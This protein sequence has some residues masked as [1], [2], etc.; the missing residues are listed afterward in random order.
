[1]RIS[2]LLR[3]E[4][5]DIVA[6]WASAAQQEVQACQRIPPLLLVDDIPGLL[7]ELADWLE[8]GDEEPAEG[9]WREAR[10]HAQSRLRQDF[11]PAQLVHEYRILRRVILRRLLVS[12]QGGRVDDFAQ[13]A[14]MGEALDMAIAVAIEKVSAVRERALKDAMEAHERFAAIASHDL[15]NPLGTIHTAGTLLLKSVELPASLL[16]HVSRIV[17]NADRTIRMI[18]DLLD[19]ARGRLSEGIPVEPRPTNLEEVARAVLGDLTTLHP[20]RRI[21]S[22]VQGRMD[23]RWDPDRLRQALENLVTNAFEHGAPEA[24]V[25][26]EL[27]DVGEQV[28]MVVHNDGEPI[29]A[30]DLPHVFDAFRHGA[31]SRSGL[32]LGLYIV[33]EIARAHGGTVELTSTSG[34][35]TTFRMTLPRAPPSPT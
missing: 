30:E 10:R 32:G 11:D 20:D 17:S 16:R 22:H 2:D 25:R 24:P 6:E 34:E 31:R 13:I 15:R 19:L 9:F 18:G 26:V 21:E 1:M 12:A 4:H 3:A 28:A 7:G 33:K 8:R 27:L 29:P 14:R 5:D 23:G 35:G